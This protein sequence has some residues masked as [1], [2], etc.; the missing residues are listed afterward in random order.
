MKTNQ[1]L[2]FR[3]ELASIL[4]SLNKPENNKKEWINIYDL[5][6][7]TSYS[8]FGLLESDYINRSLSTRFLDRATHMREIILKS[9]NG[10]DVKLD[11]TALTWISGHHLSNS[12]H[13]LAW[14]EERM[15]YQ[16][17]AENCSGSPDC[18]PL[19]K[20]NIKP[21]THLKM[22]TCKCSFKKSLEVIYR[23]NNYG[24]SFNQDLNLAWGP[25][26]RIRNITN[27]Q[28]HEVN[29]FEERI[30]VLGKNLEEHVETILAG[31]NDV[32][33]VF[34]HFSDKREN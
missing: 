25:L 20:E 29:R 32:T 34:N 10:T 18:K 11:K 27:K 2:K 28:K 22:D 23:H 19:L 8:A 14:I 1:N 7:G 16:I 17:L 5:I 21:S 3:G 30:K 4:A 13:R 24:K 15:F 26:N 33:N 31:I 9:A 12:L 6:V